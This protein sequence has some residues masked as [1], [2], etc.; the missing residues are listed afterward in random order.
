[1]NEIKTK[2]YL[3]KNVKIHKPLSIQWLIINS[4]QVQLERGQFSHSSGIVSVSGAVLKYTGGMIKILFWY[5]EQMW[6]RKRN[7][8]IWTL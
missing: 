4:L 8:S 5:S 6:K 1:M 3:E 2:I 7:A